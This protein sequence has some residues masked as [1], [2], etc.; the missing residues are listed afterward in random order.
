MNDKE[1]KE[2]VKKLKLD[3]EI[4]KENSETFLEYKDFDKYLDTIDKLEDNYKYNKQIIGFMISYMLDKLDVNDLCPA[5][6]SKNRK[7]RLTCDRCIYNYFKDRV[8]YSNR[9]E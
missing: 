4:Q 5:R 8:D 6:N 3:L 2:N 9:K 1:I 7:C